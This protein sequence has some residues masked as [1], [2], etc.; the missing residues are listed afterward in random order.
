MPALRPREA[1]WLRFHTL[2]S[3]REKGLPF[4]IRSFVRSEEE[5]LRQH[6]AP[7]T[8]SLG[9]HRPITA[10]HTTMPGLTLVPH[11]PAGGVE[12]APVAEVPP[13]PLLYRRSKP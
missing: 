7:P 12:A 11:P 6:P 5:Q 8:T 3:V 4:H 1:R 9:E 13:H 10:A 2:I